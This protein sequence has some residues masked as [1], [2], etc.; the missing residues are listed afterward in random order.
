MLQLQFAMIRVSD[1]CVVVMLT[2]HPLNN[3]LC[4]QLS[5]LKPLYPLYVITSQFTKS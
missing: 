5:T 4:F 3:F 2:F 1:L